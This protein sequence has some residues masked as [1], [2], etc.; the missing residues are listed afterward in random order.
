MGILSWVDFTL[1][2]SGTSQESGKAIVEPVV[3]TAAID[4]IVRTSFAVEPSFGPAAARARLLHHYEEL[5]E[6][7]LAGVAAGHNKVQDAVR[8]ALDTAAAGSEAGRTG[9]AEEVVSPTGTHTACLQPGQHTGNLSSTPLSW[10]LPNGMTGTWKAE[11]NLSVCQA[12]T[13]RHGWRSGVA[14]KLVLT[15][16]SGC[17]RQSRRLAIWWTCCWRTPAALLPPGRAAT[18]TR[19]GAVRPSCSTCR[20][21]RRRCSSCC[22]ILTGGS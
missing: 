16:S 6:L 15:V 12:F 2:L 13:R 1:H 14:A 10:P 21:G 19:S 18:S 4:A 8:L 3:P 9:D 17:C 22:A 5:R 11:S 20:P 7:A